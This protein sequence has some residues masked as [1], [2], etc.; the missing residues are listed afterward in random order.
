MSLEIGRLALVTSSLFAMSRFISGE[1]LSSR[2]AAFREV[3][4][5]LTGHYLSNLMR[6]RLSRQVEA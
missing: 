3:R 1:D 6:L 2:L 4:L 5:G